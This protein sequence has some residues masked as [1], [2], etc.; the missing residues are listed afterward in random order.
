MRKLSAIVL[1]TFLCAVFSSVARAQEQPSWVVQSLSQVI[2]NAPEGHVDFDWGS[3]LAHGTN[4]FIQYGGATLVADS[5]SV[6][7]KTGEVVA[8][9]HVRI[10]Q[11][12][13]I[14][15]GEHIRYNFLTHQMQSEQFRTGKPPV[16]AEG[17]QLEGDI[18]N[19]TYH[20]RHVYVTTDD[21]SN[22]DM[23]VRASR[24]KIVPGKYV[25]MWNAVFSW[26]A[27]RRFTFPIT[28][29]TWVRTR[30][31]SISRPASAAAYGPFLLNTYT[32][33]LSDMVDGKVHLD[34]R[35]KRGSGGR[36]RT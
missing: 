2:T 8:D 18:T 4:V 9:G 10:E 19:Q 25:E 20:A 7:Q 14:W 36:A 32:W 17:R 35:E 31:I 26:T 3:G 11:G 21:V 22:P 6:N 30:T 27:C 12:D 1:L 15:V 29:A 28:G 5:A 34:Y 24:I 23:R 33:F 13:Q 16:F